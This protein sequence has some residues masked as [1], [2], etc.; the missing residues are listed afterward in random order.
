MQG[1]A[2]HSISKGGVCACRICACRTWACSSHARRTCTCRICAQ[3]SVHTASRCRSHACSSRGCR[4]VPTGSVRAQE[5]CV[6]HLCN[7]DLVHARS[8][9]CRICA[10]C[11]AGSEHTAS[12]H[13]GCRAIRR[14]LVISQLLESTRQMQRVSGAPQRGRG[15]RAP[16]RSHPS[17]PTQPH[18][19]SDAPVYTEANPFFNYLQNPRECPEGRNAAGGRDADAPGAPQ[20]CPF[21]AV[22]SAPHPASLGDLLFL[23]H[24][25]LQLADKT[26]A[27]PR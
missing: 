22:A 3:R 8:C 24:Q 1:H 14:I 20:P 9:S 5:L 18:S 12:L 13:A 2:A 21:P 7:P 10:R 27:G 4:I 26:S 6:K 15:L 17:S 16:L 25:K 19:S 23:E 11:C